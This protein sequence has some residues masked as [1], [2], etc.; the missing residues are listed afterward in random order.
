MPNSALS[1]QNAASANNDIMLVSTDHNY[2][3]SMLQE[4]ENVNNLPLQSH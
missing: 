4:L 3:D 1:R 2:E